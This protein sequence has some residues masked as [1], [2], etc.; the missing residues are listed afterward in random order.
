MVSQAWNSL[1][2]TFHFNRSSNASGRA[3]F[4]APIKITVPSVGKI[5]YPFFSST[6]GSRLAKIN[7]LWAGHLMEPHLLFASSVTFLAKLAKTRVKAVMW[8]G[9]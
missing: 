4:V 9:A 7:A 6:T 5:N 8:V 1:L 3:S 2:T